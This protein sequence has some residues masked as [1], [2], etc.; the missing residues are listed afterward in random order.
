MI[1]ADEPKEVVKKI[2]FH[3]NFTIATTKEV[4]NRLHVNE[5]P[6]HCHFGMRF[7]YS[8]SYLTITNQQPLNA[9]DIFTQSHVS[10]IYDCF[11]FIVELNSVVY[12]FV[13]SE[14]YDW[15]RA[16]NCEELLE[17]LKID[18]MPENLDF[19]SLTSIVELR[20]YVSKHI[21]RLQIVIPAGMKTHK[22]EEL[23]QEEEGPSMA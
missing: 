15:L 12:T 16:R 9:S 8:V 23:L 18:K 10:D 4:R 7:D 2:H 14:I 20:I 3:E 6:S 17:V 22:S 13:V 11:A 1:F 19:M 21:E 5:V